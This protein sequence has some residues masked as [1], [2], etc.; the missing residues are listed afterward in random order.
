MHRR[1]RNNVRGTEE[2]GCA[3]DRIIIDGLR[4]RC[5]IGINDHERKQKQDVLINIELWADLKEAI[6]TDRIEASIDY[7]SV[8]KEIISKVEES[9]FFLVESLAG[10]IADTCTARHR[11]RRVRVTVEKPGALRFARSVGVQIT[12]EKNDHHG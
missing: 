1:V 7:K 5:I 4:L 3:E 10:M 8:T 12:R 2:D 6:R 11:V 9:D